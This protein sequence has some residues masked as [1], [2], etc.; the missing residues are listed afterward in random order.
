MAVCR[1]KGYLLMKQRVKS[2]IAVAAAATAAIVIILVFS[3]TIS[4]DNRTSIS[5][6]PE[7]NHLIGN[8]V[9]FNIF[10]EETRG[11]VI[12]GIFS[13]IDSSTVFYAAVQNSGKD[14]HMQL[15]GYLNYVECPL[16]FLNDSYSE[17][18]IYL[19]DGDNIIIPFRL[20]TDIESDSNY[21]LLLSLFWGTDQHEAEMQYRSDQY[22]MSYDYFINNNPDSQTVDLSLPEDKNAQ[23]T[24]SDFPTL[25]INE[26][27][28]NTDS[29]AL[30]PYV[31]T[32]RAGETFELAYKLGH[33][34]ADSTLLLVTI[35]YEQA[36]INNSTPALLVKTPEHYL[37]TGRISLTAPLTKG[38]YE[39]CAVAVPS[40]TSPNPFVV[41]E[42][43]IRFS[44]NV[45]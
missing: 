6:T 13:E 1:D 29:V 7:E 45:Q 37:A 22:T 11:K 34:T 20:K 36:V 16:E 35:G 10:T 27:F 21:K 17:D 33:I 32:V 23:Y 24:G 8:G 38:L 43:S 39:I 5:Q 28:E 3:L 9:Y 14:R 12:T 42:K 30:P 41:L 18:D 4:M 15:K 26:D 44:I 25:V 31:I 40:P 2:I 19:H